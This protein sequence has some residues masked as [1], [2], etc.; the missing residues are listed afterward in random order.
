M[1]AAAATSRYKRAGGPTDQQFNAIDLL[2][3]GRTDQEVGDAVGVHR[4]T[5]TRWRNYDVR[6]QAELNRR[7]REAWETTLDHLRTLLPKATQA[8]EEELTEGSG[9]L[10]ASLALIRMSG[11]LTAQ[12]GRS[13]L[14]ADRCGATVPEAILNSWARVKRPLSQQ[15]GDSPI[16]ED[17]RTAVAA[18]LQA[19]LDAPID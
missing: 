11:V 9:R 1:S 7:R 15:I 16:S 6:F 19:K 18:E 10:Q 5:V 2:L 8:L 13:P 3:Q 4:V 17:E 14:D 12:N